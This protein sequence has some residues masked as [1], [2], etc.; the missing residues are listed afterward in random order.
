MNHKQITIQGYKGAELR[1]YIWLP[2]DSKI[3]GVV[4][5]AHGMAEW[6]GRYDEFAKKLVNSGYKVYAND[7]RGHGNS[8]KNVNDIGFLG[9]DGFNAM[10]EDMKIVHD[11]IRKENPDVPIFLLGHSMGS[12]LAQSYVTKYGDDLKGVIYSGS[13]GK[14]GA[15]LNAGILIARLQVLFLGEKAKSKLLDS[16]TFGTYNKSFSPCRTSYDWLSREPN[17]VD[18]YVK[19]PYCGG[20]FTTSFFYDFFKGLKSLYEKENINRIPKDLP[21]CILSGKMDPV[22]EFGKGIARLEKFYRDQGIIDVHVKIYD[23][24]RHEILNETNKDEVT[25]DIIAWI[26]D[27]V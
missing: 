14:Q 7:H 1:L 12:F 8:V 26:S 24:S 15:V 16:M 9:K 2:I 17:K 6:A 10:V 11:L 3:K 18:K 20:V 23:D 19:D 5:I 13:N 22:G 27:R 21:V 25:D 4:Q